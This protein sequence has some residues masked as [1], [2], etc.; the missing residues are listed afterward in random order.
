MRM[1]RAAL[2]A[3][4]PLVALV[5][6][7]TEFV[8]PPLSQ[9]ATVWRR[10][11]VAGANASLSE[12]A[13]WFR[14]GN[15]VTRVDAVRLG[16]IPENVL[17]FE[18]DDAGRLESVM[19]A[20]TGTIEEGGRWILKNARRDIVGA[21][22]PE[23]HETFAL[24]NMLG[25][26]DL[27]LVLGRPGTLSI[28]ELHRRM[29]SPTGE[30]RAPD[31]RTRAGVASAYWKKLATPLLI[32]VMCSLAV[33]FVLGRGGALS[34]GRH[35]VLGALIGVGSHL[36]IQAIGHVGVVLALSAPAVAAAPVVVL[37]AT[38]YVLLAR[39]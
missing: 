35:L 21:P 18:R 15:R 23:Y 20:A 11:A 10:V 12:D 19:K 22:A 31:E 9:K 17:I 37:G 8:V 1:G 36:L 38:A 6:G 26:G 7:L 33:P 16:G 14:D 28:S 25:A 5:V 3:S 32:A 30:A 4:I 39:A 27:G 29:R 24:E 34:T 2:M 13:L